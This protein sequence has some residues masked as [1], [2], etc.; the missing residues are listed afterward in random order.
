[1]TTTTEVLNYIINNSGKFSLSPAEAAQVRVQKT[2]FGNGDVSVAQ[3]ITNLKAIRPAILDEYTDSGQTLS[4]EMNSAGATFLGANS[5]GNGGTW[6]TVSDAIGTTDI[7]G[8]GATLT[9][10]IA[11]GGSVADGSITTAKLADGAVTPAKLS[12]SYG[13]GS[14]QDLQTLIGS[15]DF[16]TTFGSFYGCVSGTQSF[17][18]HPDTS[19]I[20][21]IIKAVTDCATFASDG[22]TFYA[23]SSGGACSAAISGGPGVVMGTCMAAAL[24]P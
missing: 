12:D 10:A 20:S 17:T 22:N 23:S 11:A 2:K 6:I 3:L 21:E 1:M 15:A 4:D 16:G 24:E 8:S 14:N 18:V 5:F 9:A 13:S 7:S 19:S